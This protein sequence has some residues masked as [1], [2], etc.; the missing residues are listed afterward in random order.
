MLRSPTFTIT[1]P[2]ILYR[3]AAR[4]ARIR[5]VIDGYQM[6]DFSGLL[7]GGTTFDVN[8]EGKWVWH[9]QGGDLQNY[10]GRR[11]YIE[12]IDD[13]DGWIACDEIR[14]S[15]GGPE[16]VPAP[17]AGHVK[18]LSDDSVSSLE[19]LANAVSRL[20]ERGGVSP[21]VESLIADETEVLKIGRAHV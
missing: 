3:V 10:L 16:P 7:F 15:K 9:R 13:N 6:M 19:K 1:Y 20:G 21:P 18:L 14:F 17:H 5:L 4:N 2:Q 11:A 12:L 8:T